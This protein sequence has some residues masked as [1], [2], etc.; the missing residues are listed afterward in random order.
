MSR[1][2]QIDLG[3][4]VRAYPIVPAQSKWSARVGVVIEV[5]P[6]RQAPQTRGMRGGP[7]NHS[8]ERYVIMGD[9]GPPIIRCA[10]QIEVVLP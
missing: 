7:S 3:S 5:V 9:E 6:P 8:K 10:K 4:I 1:A 2:G